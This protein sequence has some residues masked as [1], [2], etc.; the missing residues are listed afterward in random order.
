MFVCLLVG[1]FVLFVWI[2]LVDL[3]VL[4]CY[5]L[6]VIC[7]CCSDFV[8]ILFWLFKIDGAYVRGH[9]PCLV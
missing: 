2:V 7:S 4:I 5:T 8:S 3:V 9:V 1:L 6:F